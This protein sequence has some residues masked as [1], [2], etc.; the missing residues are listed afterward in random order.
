MNNI[1]LKKTFI[2]ILF[3]TILSRFAFSLESQHYPQF[4][5]LLASNKDFSIWWA[6]GTYKIFKEQ[7]IPE[8][9]SDSIKIS[10]AKNEY[11]PFQ[12]VINSR[13]D[14]R[15]VKIVLSDLKNEK[16]NVIEKKNI[17]IN[18]VE[19]VNIESTTDDLGFKG[20]W[21]DPLPEYY[22]PF[23]VRSSENKPLWFTV[24]IPKDKKAGRYR[25]NIKI[26][27]E[28]SEKLTAQIEIKVFDFTLPE[29]TH[30]RT[31]YGVGLNNQYHN[32]QT[33]E[34]KRAVFDLYLQNFRKHRVSPYHPMSFYPIKEEINCEKE[35]ITLDF[36]EFDYAAKRYLD[37]FKFTGFR[38]GSIPGEICGH[39]RY[40]PEF[41]RLYKKF[42]GKIYDHLK[43][44]GWLEKAYAYWIDE[45]Q[46]D[47]WEH[48]RKGMELL[49]E[50][51]PELKRL[52]TIHVNLAPTPFF[53]NYVDI[54]VPIFNLYYQKNA[55]Q[56]QKKGEEVWWYVCTGP[57]SPYP[58]NFIDHPAINHRIRFWMIQKY[59]VDGDLYWTT[60][61]WR[62]NP[63]EV[64]MSYASDGYEYGNGDGSLLYPPQR[65]TPAEPVLKGPVN[66]IRFEM[67]R[68]GL[69]DGEYFWILEQGIERLKKMDEKKNKEY[70][71][72]GEDALSTVDDLIKKLYEF[73][74]DPQKLY[75]AR[76]NIAQVIEELGKQ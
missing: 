3:S 47:R 75:K 62:N 30:T 66:S 71:K 49:K 55:R 51:S 63:W 18:F 20:Y 35:E 40:S 67:I 53:Y 12:L 13:I 74:R 42:Y 21:P 19:Y 58:N 14:L 5:Y 8:S 64:P 39:E 56:R 76:E 31:A 50:A 52:L 24:Y 38:F 22:E 60:T 6:E 26:I 1:Y 10:A 2:I 54:W 34:D 69:E 23:D 29:E 33:T 4:G 57:K 27:P 37:E 25:G 32:V 61:Y 36:T 65:E 16:G 28:N 46:F 68:E 15:N 48:V 11:E 73:E 9:K 72:K 59:R 43:E 70:I 44:K 41:N 17:A 45:P 7:K